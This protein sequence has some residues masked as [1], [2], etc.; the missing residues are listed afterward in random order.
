VLKRCS[1]ATYSLLK[2]ISGSVQ[3][4][5]TKAPVYKERGLESRLSV[6]FTGGANHRVHRVATA[7]FWRTFGDEGKISPGW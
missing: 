2:P 3:R 5:D 7:A 6:L 1:A 4:V